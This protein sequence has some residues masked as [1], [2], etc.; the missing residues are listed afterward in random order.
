[1]LLWL[2]HPPLST[3]AETA[4]SVMK[5]S[6][7]NN[8]R[9]RGQQ[10]DRHQGRSGE[11][12]RPARR[13]LR[14]RKGTGLVAAC[15]KDGTLPAPNSITNPECKSALQ[16]S[17]DSIFLEVN[18]CECCAGCQS[19]GEG[20]FSGAGFLLVLEATALVTSTCLNIQYA[21]LGF[22]FS[23]DVWKRRFYPVGVVLSR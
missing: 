6:Q 20:V 12:L 10:T 14:R 1:M 23:V 17:K 9:G 16:L 11:L 2:R 4:G 22:F 5:R 3:D 8:F 7:H 19:H 21:C 15:A 13:R 18:M